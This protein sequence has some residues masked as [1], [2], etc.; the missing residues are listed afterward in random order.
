MQKYSFSIAF[1]VLAIILAL[2]AACGEGEP[3]NLSNSDKWVTIQNAIDEFIGDNG[4]IAKCAEEG[5]LSLASPTPS[6]SEPGTSSA[7]DPIIDPDV[8]SYSSSSSQSDDFNPDI[9]S[10]S[11]SKPINANESCPNDIKEDFLKK[12][13]CYWEPSSVISGKNATLKMAIKDPACQAGEKALKTIGAGMKSGAARFPFDVPMRTAGR[14]EDVDPGNITDASALEQAAQWPTPAGSSFIFDKVFGLLV[15]GETACSKECEPLTIN[16]AGKPLG[17]NITLICPWQELTPGNLALGV[18]AGDC[19]AG[20][21]I[22]NAEELEGCEGPYVEYCGGKTKETC[23]FSV[24]SDIKIKVAVNCKLGGIY[25]FEDK[26]ISYKVVPNPSLSGTCKWSDN[27]KSPVSSAKGSKPSGVTLANSYGRC[28]GLTDGALPT[29]AYGGNEVDSWPA[30]GIVPANTYDAV[31]TKVDCIPAIAAQ[32]SC[33]TLVV[34]AG[35]EYHIVAKRSDAQGAVFAM[36]SDGECLD[37]DYTWDDAGWAGQRVD[38]RCDVDPQFAWAET[39]NKSRKGCVKV[40]YNG[41]SSAEC[42][43]YG[44]NAKIPVI[45]STTINGVYEILGVCVEIY[46]GTTTTKTGEVDSSQKAK[47][48]A[49]IN[50]N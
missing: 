31:A 17:Q 6:Y 12:F 2:F 49:A 39:V 18:P 27:N 41:A 43:D 34:N 32:A 13:D 7:A 33:P 40:T 8:P 5:C 1:L 22:S 15:C 28:S 10:S 25:R 42:G 20:G 48:R 23:N 30:D 50:G 29:S 36:L 38:V 9:S 21:S 4:P 45:N 47:C 24:P 19:V 35:A 11:D 46:Y 44:V 37:M 16:E 26:T 14:Y 3:D